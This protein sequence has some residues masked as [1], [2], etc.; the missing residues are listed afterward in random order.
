MRWLYTTG[1]NIFVARVRSDG[2]IAWSRKYGDATTKPFT[3]MSV[4]PAGSLIAAGEFSGT[5]DFGGGVLT[6]P[7][8]DTDGYVV[9]IDAAGQYRWHVQF[10]GAQLQSVRGLA[11]QP[12]G[13]VDI[14]GVFE[15]FTDFN[16]Y[17]RESAGS[18]DLFAARLNPDGTLLWAERFGGPEADLVT[19]IAS[20]TEGNLVLTGSFSDEI[21]FGGGPLY[22]GKASNVYLARL[23]EGSIEP[24]LNLSLLLRGRAI[25][26]QWNI[27]SRRPL[28]RLVV[29]RDNESRTDPRIVAAGPIGSG[30][31]VYLDQDLAAGE[32]YRY[33]LIV[34][35]T[36]GV[37]YR[38]M[39]ATTTVPAFA[40]RLAQN[41]PNPFALTT[42][43]AYELGAP[44]EVSV[45]IYDVGGALVRRVRDGARQPGAFAV[46]WDGSDDAGRPV[47]S[48]VYFYRIEGVGGVAPRKMVLLK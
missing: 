37:E 12:N 21:D 7:I 28:E 25:E 1:E 26:A 27:S 14:A 15:G 38:G 36:T 24:T 40:N 19:A 23:G 22:G 5:V 2:S 20:D 42:S 45:G 44:A 33:E 10:G 32:T 9:S 4:D 41:A 18:S 8:D 47:G 13:N 16:G 11:V 17:P 35:T 48:G 6:S 30:Q 34:F 3:S 39:I 31:G 43:I 29:L 46:E